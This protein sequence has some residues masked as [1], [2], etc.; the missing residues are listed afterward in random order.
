M[1]EL[2]R[3]CNDVLPLN[4]GRI[5]VLRHETPFP[6][7]RPDGFLIVARVHKPGPMPVFADA[8]AALRSDAHKFERTKIEWNETNFPEN[9]YLQ[10]NDDVAKAVRAGHFASG[11]AHYK[12]FGRRENRRVK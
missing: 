4:G 8:A 1:L 12:L 3:G 11:F 10:F 2:M 7:S 6:A 5:E 9:S